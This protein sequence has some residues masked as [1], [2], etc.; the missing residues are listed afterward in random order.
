MRDRDPGGARAPL[1]AASRVHGP[2]AVRL[3]PTQRSPGDDADC[4]EFRGA[5]ADFNPKEIDAGIAEQ[6]A[7]RSRPASGRSERGVTRR[8]ENASSGPANEFGGSEA[9]SPGAASARRAD[10]RAQGPPGSS[11]RRTLEPDLV[12]LDEFQRFKHLLDVDKDSEAASLARA[13]FNWSRP[14]TEEHARVLMLSATPSGR[15]RWPATAAETTITPTSSR[16][17]RSAQRRRRRQLPARA[18]APATSASWYASRTQSSERLR[19][20]AANRG[21]CSA[22]HVAHGAARRAGQHDAML[23][24]IVRTPRVA[25]ADVQQ[26]LLTQAIADSSS[27][28]T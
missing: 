14:G 28:P 17:S 19:A 15:S 5:I 13:L 18:A 4:G 8:S 26:Y 21:R 11:L 9:R 16:P 6:F 1:L 20:S 7:K 25:A 27:S 22:L 23:H 12:I 24:Q 10:R 3:G 2:S